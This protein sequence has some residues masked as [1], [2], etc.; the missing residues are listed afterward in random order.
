[1]ILHLNQSEFCRYGVREQKSTRQE[2]QVCQQ[3]ELDWEK[4]T[5]FQTVTD[6]RIFPDGSMTVLS[7][8]LDGEKFDSFYLDQPVCIVPGVYFYL[9]PMRR[10]LSGAVLCM[11]E[12]LR[13]V[14]AESRLGCGYVQSNMRVSGIYTLFYHEKDKG[15]FFAGE[16]HPA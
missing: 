10:E 15:F 6:T 5:V 12:P 14:D 4:Q 9:A 8:S 16:A 1:M 7:V 11:E 3:I 2:G 13:I